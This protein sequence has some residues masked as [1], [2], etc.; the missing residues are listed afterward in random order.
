MNFAAAASSSAVFTT[1]TDIAAGDQLDFTTILAVTNAVGKLGAALTSGVSD[2]QTFL[3]AAAGK[4]AGTLS[5]FQFG[6]DT[7]IVQDV[8]ASNSFSAGND[9]V[10]KLTGLVDL[11]N[12][13]IAAGDVLTIV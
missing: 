7:F 4:G 2:Y 13:T 6:G 10:V 3:N 11:S 9:H 1:I 8:N 5:W 12:S